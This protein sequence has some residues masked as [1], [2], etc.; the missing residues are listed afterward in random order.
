[1][2][3]ATKQV[4][5]IAISEELFHSCFNQEAVR[6]FD[7]ISGKYAQLYYHTYPYVRLVLYQQSGYFI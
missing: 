7:I 4:D 2:N 1:M 6:A 5:K 3:I